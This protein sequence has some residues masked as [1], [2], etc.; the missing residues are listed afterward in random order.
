MGVLVVVVIVIFVII[1]IMKVSKEARLWDRANKF[2]INKD[3]DTAIRISNEC[4]SLYPNCV[5]A[6]RVRGIAY[7]GKKDYDRALADLNHVIELEPTNGYRYYL[8]SLV[9]SD[10]G[11]FKQEIADLNKS[12][13]VGGLGSVYSTVKE[14]L[15]E[16]QAKLGKT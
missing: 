11:D 3:Y 8:R 14:K 4:I 7:K 1:I 12:I 10:M 5:E 9:Y 15:A 16:A 13:E 2:L 6:Y